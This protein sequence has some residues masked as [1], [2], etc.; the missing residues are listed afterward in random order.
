MTSNLE[1]G[2]NNDHAWPERD[3]PEMECG[4]EGDVPGWGTEREGL[5][6]VASNV[7]LK[8]A[9]SVPAILDGDEDNEKTGFGDWL[10]LETDGVDNL[11]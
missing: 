3:S 6:N 8:A 10:L 7:R 9:K 4:P 11:V 2:S 5:M 1:E